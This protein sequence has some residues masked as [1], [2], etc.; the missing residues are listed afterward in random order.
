MDAPSKRFRMTP[1]KTGAALLVAAVLSIG[2]VACGSS[3]DSTGSASTVPNKE[4]GGGVITVPHLI[5]LSNFE[6][7]SRARSLGLSV[8]SQFQSG[9]GSGKGIVV[10]QDPQPGAEASEGQPI[11]LIIK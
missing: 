8:H 5:G 7:E 4:A 2:A 1:M 11:L 6:A 10:A 9:D 3:S